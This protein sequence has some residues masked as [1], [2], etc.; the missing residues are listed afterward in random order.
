MININFVGDIALFALFEERGID[1]FKEIHLPKSDYN[2]GNFEFIIPN[3][4]QKNFFD[5]SGEYAVSYSFFKNLTLNKFD[6]YS[7]ANNHC[8][9]YTIEGINDV[10]EVFNSK[11]VESFGFGENDFNVLEINKNGVSIAIL[12]FVKSG[13]WDRNYNKAGPD[14][15]KVDNINKEIIRLKRTFNHVIIFPHWGTELVDVPNPEDVSI[16]REFINLGASCVIGHHPHIIQ[17]IE[18][19]KEGVIAYSLGSFIYVPEKEVGYSKSHG[20][21]RNYS[22]CLNLQFDKDKIIK[23]TPTFYCFN[24]KTLIPE[25][26]S[27]SMIQYY[28]K[29]ICNQ[30]NKPKVYNTK[31][32]KQLF[33]REI[34]SFIQRFKKSPI[35]TVIHY[36][37]YIKVDHFKKLIK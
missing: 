25:E 2:I 35:K 1:P 34:K 36:L 32:R 19:I 30:I 26:I 27:S 22:I 16:A 31:V 7:L 33:K 17:G 24:K 4:R 6:A 15:Y 10:M 3:D 12:S 11:G 9:D 23:V 13:R 20:E 29:D 21:N 8:M 18:N 14:S 37:E 28:F 5:V